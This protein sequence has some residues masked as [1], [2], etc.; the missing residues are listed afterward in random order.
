MSLASPRLALA[1]TV[2]LAIGSLAW[3]AGG[4]AWHLMGHH[5][6]L[7]TDVA[8]ADVAAPAAPQ[9]DVAPIVALNPFGAVPEAAPAAPA[10]ETALALVLHGVLLNPDPAR[11]MALIAADGPA[12]DFRPGDAVSPQATLVEIAASHVVL[13]VDGRRETLSF[14]DPRQS[15]ARSGR[16]AQ[17]VGVNRLRAVLSAQNGDAAPAPDDVQ[18]WL[19]VWRERIRRNPGEAVAS[20]G[21]TPTAAGYMVAERHDAAPAA[22]RAPG[23]GRRDAGERPGRRRRGQRP[24]A[25]RRGGRVGAGAGRG[26]AGGAGRH[27]DV[28]AEVRGRRA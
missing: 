19:E 10:E 15:N 26:E 12:R 27:D 22:R 18:G 9:V 17:D 3:A 24:R 21:L 1:A 20:I 11:S 5:A 7:A 2:A 4:P 23:R 16:V 28:P 13:A 14:P 6:A 25:L 8:V